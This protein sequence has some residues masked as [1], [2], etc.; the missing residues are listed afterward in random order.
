MIYQKNTKKYFF[1]VILL[2]LAVCSLLLVSCLDEPVPETGSEIS[3]ASSRNYSEKN[4]EDF[5]TFSEYVD[6]LL[7]ESSEPEESE[8]PFPEASDFLGEFVPKFNYFRELI[9]NR[10]ETASGEDEDAFPYERVVSDRYDTKGDITRFLSE[11]MTL[12]RVTEEMDFLISPTTADG[13]GLPL[14]RFVDGVTW[15]NTQTSN[16]FYDGTWDLTSAEYVYRLENELRIAFNARTETG[17]VRYQA[18]FLFENG[19]WLLDSIF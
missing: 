13:T 8:M 3:N 6:W 11:F 18:D 19:V 15:M 2:I 16:S 10:L 5:S 7:G 9:N 17:E 1:A 12:S 4:E 14:Y